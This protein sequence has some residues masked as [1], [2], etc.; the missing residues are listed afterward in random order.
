M[1]DDDIHLI[2]PQKKGSIDLEECYEMAARKGAE[3]V[4]YRRPQ[5][6]KSSSDVHFNLCGYG[7]D[8]EL[9]APKSAKI[10][11]LMQENPHSDFSYRLRDIPAD[12]DS[13]ELVARFCHGYE[14][15]LST[16]NV[17]RVACLADYLEMTE[18]HCPNNLLNKALFFIE[19]QILP[20]WN[21][22]IKALKTAENV[23]EQASKLGLVEYLVE[24]IILKV[25]DNPRLLGEPIKNLTSDDEDDDDDD[26]DE[27]GGYK[28][29]ARRKLFDIDWKSEDLSSLSLKL[30]AHII[31]NLITRGIP[32]EY[33]AAN[34]CEYTKAWV[35]SCDK[36]GDEMSNNLRN[37]YKEMVETLVRVMCNLGGIFPCSF[38]CE[39]LRFAIAMHA[40]SECKNALELKIGMKLH[41]ATVKD[42]LIPSEGYAHDEKYDTESLKRMLM[43]FCNYG[44]PDN[45]GLNSVAEVIEEF[46]SEISADID[47]KMKTFLAVAEMSAAISQ[48]TQRSSDGMYRAVIIYLDKHRHLTESEKEE[49]C[50]ILDCSRMSSEACEHAAQNALLPLRVVVQVLF[51]SQLKLRE[52]IPVEG[53]LLKEEE[54]EGGKRELER[55]GSKV[56]E[57]ERECNLMRKEIEGEGGGGG[58][59]GR[60]RKLSVWGKV[61]RKIGCMTS[62]HDCNCH[63]SKKKK[64]VHP[65]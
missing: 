5:W 39:V 45:R 37:H 43:N 33:I 32:R 62:V 23:L 53:R 6:A 4:T 31:G 18:T 48:G 30:Y 26:D 15:N 51:V 8:K 11:N 22:C 50:N 7:I 19:Q 44:N 12:Q 38:L 42:L 63:V 54:E 25:L 65:R 9:L 2:F 55:M 61:K 40:D 35:F 28:V 46:L 57:L 3:Y 27:S 21:N 49:L 41:Q 64:K 47:L 59:G 24:S 60:R 10:A 56:N 14:T 17:V 29:N 58:S 34:L 1:K 16:Q 36:M 52:A 20:N 13:L